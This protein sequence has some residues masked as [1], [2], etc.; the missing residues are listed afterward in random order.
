MPVY[1]YKC[2]CGH[3]EQVVHGITS[4]PV[5]KCGECVDCV[6]SRV[7]AVGGVAFVGEGWGKDA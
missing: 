3:I 4:N 7:P 1:I 6:M 5:V 2:P